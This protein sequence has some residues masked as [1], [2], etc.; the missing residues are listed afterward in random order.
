MNNPL[1]SICIPTYNGQN[2]L[3]QCLDSVVHQTFTN[4]EIIICDDGS[5]DSTIT[6]VD[7]YALKYPNIIFY[8]NEKN[9]G[10]VGNWNKCIELAKGEWIKFVF[11]DDY[12]STE[13]LQEFASQI[14]DTNNL[15][16]SKRNFI[17]NKNANVVDRDYY[18]NHVRTLENTGHYTS[19]EFSLKMISKLAVNNI[20]LNFIGEPTLCMFKKSVIHSIGLFNPDL[21]QI[22]DLEFLQRLATNYGLTYLPVQ[23]CYF[24]IH[25]S[26][27]TS[28]NLSNNQ[29]QLSHIEP[30][31]LA[32]LMLFDT[33][34]QTF[35][36]SLSFLEKLKL[37][38]YFKVRGYEAF[39]N[40]K[41]TI[42]NTLVYNNIVAKYT[43]I[44][45]T[46]KA[47]F[48]VFSVHQ[49]VKLKRK[50]AKS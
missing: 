19:N 35:R 10:L 25:E 44:Q 12:I 15:I 29:Y 37:N 23:N 8:K 30:V 20:C 9:L 45:I 40:S 42:E 3:I 16:V 4:Y 48:V 41:H 2:Y 27:T 6:M 49:L 21:K 22:C 5:V 46:Q 13:C 32:Y 11:Q 7:D 36:N 50:F 33:Q 26:S 31:L 17:L 1:I 34:Y 43:K 38:F 47:N 28:T 18:D 39:V 24:R 14:N